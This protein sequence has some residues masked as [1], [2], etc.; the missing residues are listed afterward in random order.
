MYQYS[1]KWYK[2]LFYKAAEYAEQNPDEDTRI[3]NIYWT[4][5]RNL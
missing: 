2:E 5:L 1:L 4:F 3:K